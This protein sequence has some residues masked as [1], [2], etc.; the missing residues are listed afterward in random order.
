MGKEAAAGC[1]SCSG[2]SR[3]IELPAEPGAGSSCG[4]RG[5]AALCSL[6]SAGEHWC[7]EK[8]KTSRDTKPTAPAK[9]GHFLQEF[10]LKKKKKTLRSKIL[11]QLKGNSL[12]LNASAA[13]VLLGIF[14]CCL[15]Y[16]WPKSF[17]SLLQIP[18]PEDTCCTLV[19]PSPETTKEV[20][21]SDIVN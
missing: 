8:E 15:S 20:Q 9:M 6:P 14:N 13:F 1:K 2:S 3:S 12:C 4:Q 7:W 11:F 10:I 17:C 21:I 19:I 16:H 18:A 5:C